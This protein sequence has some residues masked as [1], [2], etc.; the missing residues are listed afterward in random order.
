MNL[1]SLQIPDT[2]AETGAWLDEL[3]VSPDLLQT[4]VE[5]ELLAGD[6]LTE[7]QSLDGVLAGKEDLVYETGLTT[8]SETTIRSLLRQPSL[9]LELQEKVM[10]HGGDYWQKKTNQAFGS[11]DAKNVVD[12][13]MTS[14]DTAPAVATGLKDVVKDSSKATDKTWTR[15]QVVSSLLALA[16]ALLVMVSIWQPWSQGGSVAKADWGFAKSGL[17]TSN[18]SE[19]QMLAKLAQASATWHN[20][21][22]STREQLEKRL[23]EFDQGCQALLGSDLPQLSVVNRNGVHTACEECRQAIAEQLAALEAGADFN[24][25]R[26]RSNAAIDQLTSSIQ[27]L[28]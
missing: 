12:S 14:S 21:K 25:T 23:L 22:P 17:L 15:K 26:S 9:L 8:A 18:V 1:K 20:K 2:I 6:R 3:L 11:S 10:M 4:I 24:Q 19:D 7:V 5:L 28:S 27:R 13:L 16:A